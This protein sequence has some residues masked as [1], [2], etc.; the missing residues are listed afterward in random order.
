M[1]KKNFMETKTESKWARAFKRLLG[2]LP[3][4]QAPID[5]DANA[6]VLAHLPAADPKFKCMMEHAYAQFEDNLRDVLDVSQPDGDRLRHANSAA[7]MKQFIEEL[8]MLREGWN[9]ERI[10]VMREQKQRMGEKSP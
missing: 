8:E 7:G 2:R 4:L 5:A 1:N 6:N 10:K 3:T 9:A